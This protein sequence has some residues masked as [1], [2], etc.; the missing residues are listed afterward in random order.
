M[1]MMTKLDRAY[2]KVHQ[3][4]QLGCDDKNYNW[5]DTNPLCEKRYYGLSCVDVT[6]IQITLTNNFN[7]LSYYYISYAEVTNIQITLTDNIN[8]LSYYDISCGD[9][10]NIQIIPKDD[11]Y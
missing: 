8:Q 1:M 9:V 6:N 3:T 4:C 5:C 11:I 2:I 7:L 10:N